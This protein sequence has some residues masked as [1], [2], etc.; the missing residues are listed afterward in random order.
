MIDID[1][2]DFFDGGYH[3]QKNGYNLPLGQFVTANLVEQRYGP[4]LEEE[5]T[6]SAVLACV[7][8][9]LLQLCDSGKFILS[10]L[11][12]NQSFSTSILTS[13]AYISSSYWF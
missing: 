5:T 4:E 11:G 6:Y 9:G 10:D 12:L 7:Y 3:L 2:V 8:H 1:F 13:L